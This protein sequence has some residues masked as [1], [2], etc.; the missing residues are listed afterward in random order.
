[1]YEGAKLLRR[2]LGRPHHRRDHHPENLVQDGGAAPRNARFRWTG[3]RSTTRLLRSAPT[4]PFGKGCSGRAADTLGHRSSSQVLRAPAVRSA[5]ENSESLARGGA[6]KS[7]DVFLSD[8]DGRT[9][10]ARI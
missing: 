3:F 1:E 2:S 8:D 9:T 4:S 10:P 5:G 6:G 7:G